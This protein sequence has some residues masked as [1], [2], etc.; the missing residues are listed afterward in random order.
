MEVLSCMARQWMA[1]EPAFPSAMWSTWCNRLSGLLI[2]ETP[3]NSKTDSSQ[4]EGVQVLK[5][6]NL[7]HVIFLRR[8]FSSM[9]WDGFDPCCLE[10]IPM[11]R[12]H[13][14]CW[15]ILWGGYLLC[16]LPRGILLSRY[17]SSICFPFS[18]AILKFIS[19]VSSLK[20]LRPTDFWTVRGIQFS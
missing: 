2:D 8:I 11:Q 19:L 14:K 12:P 20:L 6:V 15:S 18:P 7:N 16:K 4:S 1:N 9:C 17:L 13:W 10:T 5:L 3:H